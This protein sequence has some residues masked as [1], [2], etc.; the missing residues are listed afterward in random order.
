MPPIPRLDR[1]VGTPAAQPISISGATSAPTVTDQSVNEVTEAGQGILQKEKERFDRA[2]VNEYQLEVDALHNRIFTEVRNLK[3]KNAAYAQGIAQEEWNKGL[4]AIKKKGLFNADQRFAADET[5]QKLFGDLQNKVNAHSG[6]EIY[7]YEVEMSAAALE[8]AAAKAGQTYGDQQFEAAVADAAKAAEEHAHLVGA[9]ADMARD[10]ARAGALGYY[11]QSQLDRGDPLEAKRM[12]EEQSKNLPDA[13][14]EKIEKTFADTIRKDSIDVTAKRNADVLFRANIM[15]KDNPNAKNMAELTEMIM[16]SD[17]PAEIK[18]ETIKQLNLLQAQ[19]DNGV[20]A[21][22]NAIIREALNSEAGKSGNPLDWLKRNPQKRS[23]LSGEGL[24]ALQKMDERFVA[25]KAFRANIRQQN[26][27]R[28]HATRRMQYELEYVNKN[29][30]SPLRAKIELLNS[31]TPQTERTAILK[32]ITEIGDEGVRGTYLKEFND[33]YNTNPSTG[34]ASG[35]PFSVANKAAAAAAE[36]FKRV[37]DINANASENLVSHP[38]V[39][40]E[41]AK[42][43][44]DVNLQGDKKVVAAQQ[45]KINGYIQDQA[46]QRLHAKIQRRLEN[47]KLPP[48]DFE[49]E[50][51]KKIA[52]D[53]YLEEVRA[54]HTERWPGTAEWQVQMGGLDKAMEDTVDLTEDLRRTN[55][56]A[57][58][59]NAVMNIFGKHITNDP[60]MMSKLYANYLLAQDPTQQ[61]GYDGRLLDNDPSNDEEPIPDGEYFKTW[62]ALDGNLYEMTGIPGAAELV[63]E[64]M[65]NYQSGASNYA[66]IFYGSDR[67]ID[68][69]LKA[70]QLNEAYDKNKAQEHKRTIGP[71]SSRTF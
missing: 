49:S 61:G 60:T 65:E 30:L 45:K 20:A 43:F 48:V 23:Q 38:K 7:K 16:S 28:T 71:D 36:S 19:M 18:S 33:T 59:N 42:Q 39:T 41:E 40:F 62:K 31:Q 67:L 9:D 2:V 25:R 37:L 69:Q 8:N 12:L 21:A 4:K 24:R 50:Q 32:E 51:G 46:E 1:Q 55:S 47:T 68:M 5:D 13:M 17:E 22:D 56:Y 29:G 34:G 11:L 15:D 26:M 57:T 14:R 63:Q 35:R 64:Y 70:S 54:L 58:F 53:M 3:G 27:Y 52:A 10:S 44:V 6:Q 66:P